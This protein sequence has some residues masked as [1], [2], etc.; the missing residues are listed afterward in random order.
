[1][2]ISEPHRRAFEALTSREHHNFALLHFVDK[3]PAA[4]TIAVNGYPPE[5]GDSENEYRVT[6]L[7]VSVTDG[8]VLTAHDGW[9]ASAAVRCSAAPAFKP[10]TVPSDTP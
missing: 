4:A 10:S 6:P 7:C 5:D 8:I 9:E 3:C 2:N 1:M